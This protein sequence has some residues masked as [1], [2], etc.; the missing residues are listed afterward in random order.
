[1]P[2]VVLGQVDSTIPLSG[3][4]LRSLTSSS[5]FS[6]S[7]EILEKAVRHEGSFGVLSLSVSQL[8][9][10]LSLSSLSLLGVSRA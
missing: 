3:L 5:M 7:G 6:V 2:P 9:Q 4:L 10:S 1:M 8:C